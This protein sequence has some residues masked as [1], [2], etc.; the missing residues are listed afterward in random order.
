MAQHFIFVKCCIATDKDFVLQLTHDRLFFYDSFKKA[1][2]S[3][4]IT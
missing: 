3:E 2:K 4:V 1:K